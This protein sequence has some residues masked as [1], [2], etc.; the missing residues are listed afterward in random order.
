MAGD[1]ATIVI[2]AG[3]LVLGAVPRMLHRIRRLFHRV[4]CRQMQVT[5]TGRRGHV[6][7]RCDR[8]LRRQRQC[9]LPVMGGMTGVRR[10]RSGEEEASHH[11]ER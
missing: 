7:R 3:R 11:G 8:G 4:L 10:R 6:P 1:R 5:R 9:G 2:V